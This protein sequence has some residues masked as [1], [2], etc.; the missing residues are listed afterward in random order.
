MWKYILVPVMTCGFLAAASSSNL[1]AQ[2][3]V[4]FG[5]A[6]GVNLPMGDL[7]DEADTGWMVNAL[8]QFDIPLLPLAVRGDFH[9]SQLAETGDH[10][11]HEFRIVGGSV[12]GVYSVVPGP[13]RL[14]VLG[15]VGI[16]NV[17][18]PHG[19]EFEGTNPGI[20]AGAGLELNLAVIRPFVEGR[21]HNI[22]AEESMQFAPVVIGIRF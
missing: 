2:S 22:F 21:F 13:A 9:F 5:A 15:G 12:S 11:D 20:H 19:E 4:S 8:V 16:Y 18:D 17:S 3:P 6:G 1:H 7:S 10:D 14:Y